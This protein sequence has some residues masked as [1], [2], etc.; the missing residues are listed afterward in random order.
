MARSAL[1]GLRA[2]A[3][4][5]MLLTAGGMAG[6]GALAHDVGFPSWQAV[7]ATVVVWA[8][9]AQVV[10]GGVHAAGAGLL[11]IAVAAAL[12][13]MRRSDERR[14]GQEGVSRCRSRGE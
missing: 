7:L 14:V 8:L 3:G 10:A 4:V 12:T 11:A 1:A 6:F 9:P 5:P 2:A 13:S